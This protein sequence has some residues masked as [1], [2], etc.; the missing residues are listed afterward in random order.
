MRNKKIWGFLMRFFATYFFMFLGYS[1]WLLSA[2]TKVPFFETDLITRQVAKST[3][4]LLKS[5]GTNVYVDQHPSELSLRLYINDTYVAR[6]VEGCNGISIM[7]LFVA[8][9]VAFKGSWKRTTLFGFI[10]CVSIYLV[11]V[12]RIALLAF[13]LFHFNSYEFFLH[14]FLFPALLYGYVFLLWLL[15]VNRL[16]SF[17][18]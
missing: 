6:V 8:F 15:W 2:E 3:D 10:G 12:L 9:L 18:S 4:Y 17:K 7:I 1:L 13:M 11:N 16:S 5:F 14:D